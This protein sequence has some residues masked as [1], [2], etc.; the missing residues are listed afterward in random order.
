MESCYNAFLD[1]F[2]A[3]GDGVACMEDDGIGIVANGTAEITLAACLH[4]F[5]HR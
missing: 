3:T 4:R 2:G 1:D 5:I